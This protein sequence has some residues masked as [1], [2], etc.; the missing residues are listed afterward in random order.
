MAPP[1]IRQRAVFI[2]V[3]VQARIF[4]GRLGSSFFSFVGRER[5]ASSSRKA[6]TCLVSAS[7]HSALLLWF[8]PSVEQPHHLHNPVSICIGTA[9]RGCSLTAGRRFRTEI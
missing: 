5:L 1:S 3:N 6:F 4:Q 9:G 7:T 8:P 2:P